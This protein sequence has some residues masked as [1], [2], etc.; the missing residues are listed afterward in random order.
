MAVIVTMHVL[1]TDEAAFVDGMNETIRD[2]QTN[3][4]DLTILDWAYA[5]PIRSFDVTPHY[6]E[7]DFCNAIPGY[8]PAKWPWMQ[9][10]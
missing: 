3:E 2:W 8:K 1:V 4:T 7:G 5:D 10:G 9:E 6:A